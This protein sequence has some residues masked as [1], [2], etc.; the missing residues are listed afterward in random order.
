MH[1]PNQ[2]PANIIYGTI[3]IQARFDEYTLDVIAV[4]PGLPFPTAEK[5]PSPERFLADEHAV[6]CLPGALIRQFADQV[7]V[8]TQKE[9]QRVTL[10]FEH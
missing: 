7:V 3:D 8:D 5:C 2:Q 9:R 10:H 4:Y 6:M 1:A